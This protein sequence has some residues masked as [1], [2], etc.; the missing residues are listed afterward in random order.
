MK[1]LIINPKNH[2]MGNMF[3]I[4]AVNVRKMDLTVLFTFTKYPT[5]FPLFTHHDMFV[6]LI[7]PI[8]T[9]HTYI[10]H[11]LPF[12][13]HI[14]CIYQMLYMLLT[15]KKTFVFVFL[16]FQSN[17]A[18]ICQTW[19]KYQ[20]ENNVNGHNQQSRSYEL[21]LSDILLFFVRLAHKWDSPFTIQISFA[22]LIFVII[23]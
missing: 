6:Y 5:T 4:G 10:Q 19:K 22:S 2:S 1:A 18:A 20:N 14:L 16:P 8:K 15:E 7:K 11:H 12:T 21:S 13:I 3:F 17:F 9:E 23:V